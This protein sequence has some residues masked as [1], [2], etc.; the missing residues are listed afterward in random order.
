MARE[1][2]ATGL[3]GLFVRHPTAANLLMAA[4]VLVGLYSLTRMNIQFFPTLEVPVSQSRL[5]GLAPAPPM[6]RRTFSIHWSRNS[7]FLTM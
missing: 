5:P 1:N 2:S 3:I 6:S 7:G 4:V